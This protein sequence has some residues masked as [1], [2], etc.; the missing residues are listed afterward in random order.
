MIQNALFNFSKVSFFSLI[1]AVG[2]SAQVSLAA[3]EEQLGYTEAR[4]IGNET[5]IYGPLYKRD[6]YNPLSVVANQNFGKGPDDSGICR[7]IHPSFVGGASIDT[8]T[9][10][11]S[12]QFNNHVVYTPDGFHVFIHGREG[13]KILRVVKCWTAGKPV[14]LPRTRPLTFKRVETRSGVHSYTIPPS[15]P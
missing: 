1:F 8:Y 15:T 6:D 2:L 4:T 3:E 14:S 10:D 5:M 11:A 9:T 7:A 13:I 12:D